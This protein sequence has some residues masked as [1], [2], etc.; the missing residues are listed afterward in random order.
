M[1]DFRAADPP[2]ARR[3]WQ[4][5]GLAS[6]LGIA[7]GLLWWFDPAKSPVPLCSLHALTGLDCPGCGTLRATHELLH[8]RLLSALRDNALWTLSLPLVLYLG[9]SELHAAAGRRPLPGD[10]THKPW[11]WIGV[12]IMATVFFVLRNLPWEPFTWLTPAG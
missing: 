1:T 9:V 4:A 6:V 12:A 2:H 8:G 10:V 7:L 5:G 11:F 3:R